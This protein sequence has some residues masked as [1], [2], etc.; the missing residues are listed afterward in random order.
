ML[1][2]FIVKKIGGKIYVCGKREEKKL[3]NFLL[4]CSGV[5]F[6]LVWVVGFFAC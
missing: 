1:K 3:A 2:Y 6:G 5:F 4:A